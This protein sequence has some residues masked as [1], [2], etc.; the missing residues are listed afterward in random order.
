[1]NGGHDVPITKIV[2]RYQKSIINCSRIVRKVPHRAY[3]YDNFEKGY[4]DSK[5]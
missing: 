1:M 3:L 4:Q 2:S 5:G